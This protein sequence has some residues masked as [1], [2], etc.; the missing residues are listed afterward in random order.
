MLELALDASKEAVGRQDRTDAFCAVLASACQERGGRPKVDAPPPGSVPPHNADFGRSIDTR[1]GVSD[2]H[3]SSSA[4]PTPHTPELP[5]RIRTFS[6]SVLTVAL[7]LSMA[8]PAAASTV[9]S[10]ELPL[11]PPG[12]TE[13]RTVESLY[14][15]VTYTRIERAGV[16]SGVPGLNETIAPQGANAFA[17][18]VGPWVVHVL[19]IAA[20]AQVELRALLGQDTVVGKELTSDAARRTPNAIAAVNGGYFVVGDDAGI[21]GEPA[22]IGVY[23]GALHSE[24][25]RGRSALVID[26]AAGLPG[27]LIDVVGSSVTVTAGDIVL[28]A[29]GI[30]RR[31]GL[32]R[33]CGGGGDDIAP[34]FADPIPAPPGLGGSSRSYP[35]AA[36]D[37]TC[38]DDDE[39]V[40][41][42]DRLGELVRAEGDVAVTLDFHGVV[43]AIG[44]PGGQTVPTGGHVLIASGET[45][46]RLSQLTAI[47][48]RIDVA[49]GITIDGIARTLTGDLDVVN[50]G[51]QLVRDGVS[52]IRYDEEGFGADHPVPGFQAYYAR[53]A[54][55]RIMVGVRPDGGLVFVLVDGRKLDY[56]N[57]VSFDEAAALL[58]YLGADTGLLLDGGGSATM[59]RGDGSYLNSPPGSARSVSDSIVL[60]PIVEPDPTSTMVASSVTPT[61]PLP[62]G[63]GHATLFLLLAAAVLTRTRRRATGARAV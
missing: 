59:T 13:T 29:D 35:G 34:L 38:T 24:A 20:D 57:G 16:T 43:T 1:D 53:T 12:L 18:S 49:T 39:L 32:I 9:P 31:L 56:S 17:P 33:M 58:V 10:D 42:T 46:D 5:V 21:P 36:H 25:V 48:A 4:R 14:A 62:S 60:V 8:G 30:D 50:G 44:E 28:T 26:R 19:E 63:T 6:T 7:M 41:L 22:G 51:P 27:T 3:A 23:G 45:A 15:G 61:T 54:Q 40:V 55:P 2:A 47:G 37:V 11:G 52:A